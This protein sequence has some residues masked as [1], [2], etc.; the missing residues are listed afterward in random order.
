MTRPYYNQQQK[1]RTCKIVDFSVPADQSKIEESE[2]KDKYLNLVRELKKLRNMKVT[3]I[4]ILID[5]LGTVT[6]GLIKRLEDLEIRG[7]VETIQITAII[8][9]SQNTEKSPGDLR[10]FAVTQTPVKDHQLMLMWKNSQGVIIIMI[11]TNK[12]LW[13]FEIQMAHQFLARRPDQGI[14]NNNKKEKKRELAE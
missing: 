7:Q 2:E 9:I 4:P 12:V 13:D 10:R 14:V 6:K 3:F 8:E 5:V 1:K 11:E